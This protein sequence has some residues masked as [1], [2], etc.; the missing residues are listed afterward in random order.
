MY[1]KFI[2]ID[3][4]ID[5]VTAYFFKFVCRSRKV[6][7]FGRQYQDMDLLILMPGFIPTSIV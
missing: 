3:F 4:D 1:I 6:K 5:F 2:S 7:S